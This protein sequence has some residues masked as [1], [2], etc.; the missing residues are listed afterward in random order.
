MA[1]PAKG[2][3]HAHPKAHKSS[4]AS[5]FNSPTKLG[6]SQ[7]RPRQRLRLQSCDL[8]LRP[9]FQERLRQGTSASLPRAHALLLA[10][11][12]A[13]S[14]S[15]HRHSR[16][17]PLK[18]TASHSV[19][20]SPL[21]RTHKSRRTSTRILCGR[22]AAAH[23]RG[24][25][26]TTD[27]TKAS[28]CGPTARHRPSPTG[29]AASRRTTAAVST[30]CHWASTASTASAESAISGWTLVA[31]RATTNTMRAPRSVR[32]EASPP[33]RMAFARLRRRQSFCTYRRRRRGIRL[34]RTASHLA[35]TSHPSTAPPRT[36]RCLHSS[37]AATR[38]SG[39]TT[40]WRASG[41]GWTALRWT[42]LAGLQASQTTT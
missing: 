37:A 35:A 28:L 4:A 27:P 19:A 40:L 3:H 21:S 18:R 26:S 5:Q 38:G 29:G 1:D 22:V 24:S 6:V 23:Q 15:T 25:A 13:H 32:W 10:W 8:P 30:A 7:K 31:H 16:G 42:T 11:T 20:I 14:S 36:P 33:W 2:G 9:S 39:S 34:A 41:Y 17:T 12:P